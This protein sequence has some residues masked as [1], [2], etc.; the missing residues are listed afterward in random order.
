MKAL[1]LTRYGSPFDLKLQELATP[2]RFGD[3][4]HV[5]KIVI[6]VA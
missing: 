5:G 1:V 2:K 3:S 6:R 4:K